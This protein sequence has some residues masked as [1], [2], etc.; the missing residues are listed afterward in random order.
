MFEGQICSLG[1]SGTDV[2]IKTARFLG[3]YQP[4]HYAN[5]VSL[6][7]RTLGYFHQHL[8]TDQDAI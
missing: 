4:S 7:E 5:R 3:M 2:V 1:G 8:S 6:N